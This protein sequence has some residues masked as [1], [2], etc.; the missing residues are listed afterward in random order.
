M[1]V[2]GGFGFEGVLR[3]WFWAFID[4]DRK[5]K[6]DLGEYIKG[7]DLNIGIFLI[8]EKC[9]RELLRGETKI[10]KFVQS[11]KI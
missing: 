7:T 4:L 9:C 2:W 10:K 6:R 8:D 5:Q 11:E 1:V 3:G